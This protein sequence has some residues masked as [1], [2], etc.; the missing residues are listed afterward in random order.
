MNNHMEQ[1]HPIDFDLNDRFKINKLPSS[2]SY[3][4]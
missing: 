2:L 1:S 4:T 3:S